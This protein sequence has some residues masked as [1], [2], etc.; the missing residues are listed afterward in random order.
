MAWS[1]LALNSFLH[2][3]SRFA[4]RCR[5]ANSCASSLTR[6][7]RFCSRW[8]RLAALAAANWSQGQC[9]VAEAMRVVNH[10]PFPPSPLR[11]FGFANPRLL[12]CKFVLQCLLSCLCHPQAILFFLAFL[13][14]LPLRLSD[15]ANAN[16]ANCGARR[17]GNKG[18][19]RNSMTLV[20]GERARVDLHPLP[21]TAALACGRAE[22]GT[23]FAEA[24]ARGA[25]RL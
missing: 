8:Y 5:R 22:H 11:T 15:F 3:S 23:R 20:E 4:D 2:F 1:H 14:L 25:C 19:K 9:R 7:R 13:S 6:S 10:F 17:T 12:L 24:A 18:E 21:L 16:L